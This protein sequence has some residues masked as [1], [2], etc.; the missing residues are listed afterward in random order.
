MNGQLRDHP[1]AEL[2]H[3]ITDARLSGALRL[4]HERVKGAIYFEGGEIVAALTN[5]RA[6]RLSE[7]LR[8]D[9]AVGAERL[10]ELAV[11]GMP[12][13]QAGAALVAAGALSV[14][15]LDRLRTRQSSE[16]LREL[17]G[18]P[19]G[20][21]V[22]DPR[23]RLSGN[24]RAQLNTPQLLVEGARRLEA[25]FVSGRMSNDEELLSPAPEA[26]GKDA[27]S[28]LQLMPTEA[29]VLTR[30]TAPMRLSELIAI[31][32]LPEA[33]TRR[34]LYTLALGGLLR[35]ARWPHAFTQE[36]LAV[37]RK[38]SSTPKGEARE[39]TPKPPQT[40]TTATAPGPPP[41][42]ASQPET[43]SAPVEASALEEM[44]E[45]F[46]RARAST[47][48]SVLGVT[49]SASTEEVK[50]AYYALARRF[51]PDRFRRDSDE[52]LQQQLDNAFA[53]VAAAYDV[54]KDSSLRAAYDL[55]L[56][57]A[58]GREAEA[59]RTSG[60]AANAVAD[61]PAQTEQARESS[62]LYRAEDKFQ[63]GLAALQKNN[64]A[65]ATRLLGEAALLVPKQARYR[66][67][68]GRALS[69]EK[70]TRRQAESELQAA[71]GLDE[72][73]PAYRVM[74]AELYVEIGLRR[75]AESELERALKYDPAHAAARRLLR[76][77]RAE[78]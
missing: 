66:A 75:R 7:V 72:K 32:G 35:R 61:D 26:F 11:E 63:Q 39:E 25:A 23:V 27:A 20:A 46:E 65:L 42:E 16:C 21:W 64:T 49:R 5:L 59:A 10:E 44:E 22:F 41:V 6:H 36:M 53:K 50:R 28:G 77:L 73:N 31:S 48:Y 57:A 33:E 52:R 54:L 69:R 76:Q 17:L 14:S 3:E 37:A 70:R 55:K 12:D 58:E 45:L 67:L 19:E 68:Y 43:A 30:A 29:F 18:W 24:Y 78:K 9:G 34:A 1:L 62:L 74:L 47:H 40:P 2:I 56:K 60:A 8:R 4:A 38:A 13:E 51:H 71:V 15:D